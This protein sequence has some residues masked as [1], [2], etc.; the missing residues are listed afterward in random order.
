MELIDLPPEILYII[1]EKLNHKD[2]LSM[3]LTCW[4]LCYSHKMA[5]NINI[6]IPLYHH[7][8][9]VITRIKEFIEAAG[10]PQTC[11][12][13]GVRYTNHCLTCFSAITRMVRENTLGI[14]APVGFGKTRIGIV[15]AL[16]HR[17][18]FNVIISVSSQKLM[19]VW[20]RELILLGLYNK[21]PDCSIFVLDSKSHKAHEVKAREILTS[22]CGHQIV[23]THSIRM[24]K[25][26]DKPMLFIVDESHLKAYRAHAIAGTAVLLS[27]T[28]TL[29]RNTYEY[30]RL[31]SGLDVNIR[32]VSEI[33]IEGAEFPVIVDTD[34][35]KYRILNYNVWGGKG[36]IAMKKYNKP[37]NICTVIPPNVAEG[38][39]F[40]KTNRLIIVN[41]TQLSIQRVRQ[42]LG[43]FI[44]YSNV[45]RTLNID[46][47]RDELGLV[48]YIKVH[49]CVAIIETN[50]NENAFAL[51]HHTS[52]T[53]I[54]DLLWENSLS[55]DLLTH[56]DI[57][58]IFTTT[59]IKEFPYE[60][61]LPKHVMYKILNLKQ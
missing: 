56:W 7:Q 26:T 53:A 29:G 52:I 41:M 19:Y 28:G 16:L 11:S 24:Y 40:N 34:I 33:N 58:S 17:F 18:S 1:Y 54:Y 44:R 22:N 45:H 9:L 13:H 51:I 12:T 31:I 43:R 57:L 14:I 35:R 23:I 61:N 38:V 27:A 21:N 15:A 5:Y 3:I 10:P 4:D 48:D 47:V 8:E 2:K 36:V 42:L 6:G 37:D 49:V 20:I 55:L 50:L 39:N 46:C 25:E 30:R 59:L 32:S 60:T